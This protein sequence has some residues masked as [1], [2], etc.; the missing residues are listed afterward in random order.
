MHNVRLT[1]S[2]LLCSIILNTT[3]MLQLGVRIRTYLHI[4]TTSLVRYLSCSSSYPKFKDALFPVPQN[5]NT[6]NKFNFIE[7]KTNKIA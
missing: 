3:T 6:E 4:L 2:Q 1:R 5:A 7:N